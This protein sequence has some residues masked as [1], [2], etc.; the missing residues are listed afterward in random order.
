[1]IWFKHF[2]SSD[3]LF[4]KF[5]EFQSKISNFD[6]NFNVVHGDTNRCI[7]QTLEKP[8]AKFMKQLFNS[9]RLQLKISY[10]LFLTFSDCKEE[11]YCLFYEWTS[12]QKSPVLKQHKPASST[13]QRSKSKLSLAIWLYRP[14]ALH[15]STGHSWAKWQ[16]PAKN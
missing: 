9:S 11:T 12:C 8:S 3:L 5:N 10:S 16:K 14:A 7:F 13:Q 4:N 1:L 2:K 15:W 6:E